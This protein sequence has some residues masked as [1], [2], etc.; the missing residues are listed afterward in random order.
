MKLN[1]KK[2]VQDIDK[3]V[4]NDWCENMEIKLLPK[5]EPFTQK[6]ARQMAELIARVYSISHCIFCQACGRKYKIK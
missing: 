4:N 2:M 5:S 6:E 1:Y 3:L